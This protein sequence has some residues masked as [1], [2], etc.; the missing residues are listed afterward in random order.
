MIRYIE[1]VAQFINPSFSTTLSSNKIHPQ[2]DPFMSIDA[3]I[4]RAKRLK[5][6][7]NVLKIFTDRG[8]KL[9]RHAD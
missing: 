9:S 6:Q 1:N 5:Q 3:L 7:V 8:L 4:V 2:H